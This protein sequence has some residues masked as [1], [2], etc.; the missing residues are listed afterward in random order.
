[1]NRAIETAWSGPGVTVV[2]TA[3]AANQVTVP[4]GTGVST[5]T[6]GNTGNWYAGMTGWVAAHEAGH[7]MGLR[8]RY[9]VPGC[10][11]KNSSMGPG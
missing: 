1:M 7:L 11:A 9:R 3:G 8:D 6:N 5:V 2:V 10:S 4:N